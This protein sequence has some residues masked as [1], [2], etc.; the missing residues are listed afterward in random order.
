MWSMLFRFLNSSNNTKRKE[1]L[2]CVNVKLNVPFVSVN[3]PNKRRTKVMTII[4]GKRGYKKGNNTGLVKFSDEKEAVLY[5]KTKQ[6]TNIN[7]TIIERKN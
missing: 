2:L 7:L 5:C 1:R 4:V 3:K 6:Q